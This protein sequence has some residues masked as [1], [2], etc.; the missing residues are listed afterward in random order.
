MSNNEFKN[1]IDKLWLSFHAGGVANPLTVIE[2]ITFLMFVR[3]M[4]I[5]D[6]RNQRR[7]ER[8]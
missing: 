1:K 7:D 8:L 3:L 2:Q 6:S 4:D 5:T